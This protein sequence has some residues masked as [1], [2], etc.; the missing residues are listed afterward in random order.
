VSATKR[1]I[2]NADDLGAADSVNRGILEAHR[3]G[4]LTSA[5]VAV[6][7]EAATSVPRLAQDAP[8][9]GLGLRLTF[10]D[11][12]RARPEDLVAE[13]RAQLRR[14]RELLARDPTHLDTRDQAHRHPGALEALLV[15]AWETGFP[16]R[17]E[18]RE[19]HERLRRE[20]I[21]TTDRVTAAFQG[22]AATLDALVALISE[23]PFGTSDVA[24]RVSLGDAA[25]EGGAAAGRAAMDALTH[26]EARQ[27]LQA[28]GVRLI[29]YGDL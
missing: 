22:A 1:L 14:F 7:G 8:G 19:L 10:A 29:H 6:N 16:V 3:R 28:A 25:G 24:C 11:L 18:S 23:L 26:R 13:A 21:R 17:N 2:L 15:L 20:N 4:I 9:L 5:S 12:E 27:A